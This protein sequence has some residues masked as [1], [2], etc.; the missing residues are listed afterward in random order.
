MSHGQ[1]FISVNRCSWPTAKLAQLFRFPR[2]CLRESFNKTCAYDSLTVNG[3]H[4]V[5]GT[6]DTYTSGHLR[7]PRPWNL[8]HQRAGK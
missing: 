6:W 7:Q 2:L 8:K 3:F 4:Y 1:S 5:H